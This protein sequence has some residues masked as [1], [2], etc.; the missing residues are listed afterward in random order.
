MSK[1]NNYNGVQEHLHEPGGSV[2]RTVAEPLR[3]IPILKKFVNR[4]GK[5]EGVRAR[6]PK[7]K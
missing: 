6:S 4:S 5:D 7:R 2:G 1:H 3:N